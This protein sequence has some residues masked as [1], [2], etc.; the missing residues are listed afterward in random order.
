MWLDLHDLPIMDFVQDVVLIT[1]A[2][3]VYPLMISNAIRLSVFSRK[4]MW[5]YL[6]DLHIIDFVQG[7]ILITLAPFRLPPNDF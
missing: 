2:P 5:L 6:H 4:N 7:V 3:L 1:L